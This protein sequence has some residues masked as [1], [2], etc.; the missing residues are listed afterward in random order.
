MIYIILPAY[1]E[2]KNL[3]EI[4]KKINSLKIVKKI[5]VILVD[6]CSNDNTHQLRKY[7][8]KFKFS[9]FRNEKNKG[10]SLTLKKGF[11]SLPHKLSLKDLIV[12]LD[13]D[14]THPIEII[15][16]M[17]KLMKHDNSDIVIASRFLNK[18]MVKGLSFFRILLSYFAKI[19]LSFLFPYKNLKEYTCNFRIYKPYLIKKIIEEKKLFDN[20]DFSIAVKIILF[21]IKNSKNLVISEYPL[22]LNYHYKIG[23]SKMKIFKNI[24]LTL[25]LIIKK[26]LNYL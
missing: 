26:K 1:N 13:S 8:K 17:I 3:K 11:K 20:E 23:E 22:T 18:S 14:N 25:K 24:Y 19:I 2:N 9:Y 6:D 7:K 4:F 21:L 16:K 5:K 12:T 15:P 10:L